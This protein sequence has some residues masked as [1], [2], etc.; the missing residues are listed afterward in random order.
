MAGMGLCIGGFLTGKAENLNR[1]SAFMMSV[2]MALLASGIG[3]VHVQA[4]RK[5]AENLYLTACFG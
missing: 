5:I 4:G 3:G 2:I 1:K